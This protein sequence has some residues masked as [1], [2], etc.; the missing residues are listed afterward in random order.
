MVFKN[1][2]MA[3]VIIQFNE[4]DKSPEQ[5]CLEIVNEIGEMAKRMD[6]VLQLKG[7][8]ANFT[9]N[10]STLF[11]SINAL[12]SEKPI[13]EAMTTEFGIIG[14]GTLLKTSS[15]SFLSRQVGLRFEAKKLEDESIALFIRGGEYDRFPK[16]LGFLVSIING[17][18]MNGQFLVTEDEASKLK[19][20]LKNKKDTFID[21]LTSLSNENFQAITG[22]N[23]KDVEE[24]KMRSL[25]AQL[26]KANEV[27]D[28]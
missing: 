3:S 14:K 25:L 21:G 6:E 15:D 1:S 5:T 26:S 7:T 24:E 10:F 18:L 12:D 22:L 19:D 28:E 20:F 9:G 11:D 17:K 4:G 27:E 13:D 23:K 16:Q 8:Q 2:I